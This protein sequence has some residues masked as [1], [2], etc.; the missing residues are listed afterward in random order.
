MRWYSSNIYNSTDL[1]KFD[2]DATTHFAVRQ[3]WAPFWTHSGPPSS[4]PILGSNSSLRV[5]I[6]LVKLTSGRIASRIVSSLGL[7]VILL[8]I[9]NRFR[10]GSLHRLRVWMTSTML[11]G[12]KPAT[13]HSSNL[14][15][16]VRPSR[17]D[18]DMI[19][20]AKAI[21]SRRI[22]VCNLRTSGHAR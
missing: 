22:S 10:A 20:V 4:W 18:L 7:S 11:E 5:S 2:T 12:A 21:V 14:S 6:R 16:G 8:S 13:D 19:G 17:F 3:F 9:R 15:S 1:P